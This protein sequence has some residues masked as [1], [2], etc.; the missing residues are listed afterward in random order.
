MHLANDILFR[1]PFSTSPVASAFARSLD[2]VFLTGA[3]C[4]VF[5]GRS[6][7]F[8]VKVLRPRF[9]RDSTVLPQPQLGSFAP[10][11][12]GTASVPSSWEPIAQDQKYLSAPPLYDSD[13][14]QQVS[15]NVHQSKL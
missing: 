15:C 12:Y 2:D 11:P 9:T 10:A 7:T 1:M 4:A 3:H 8:H 6:L 13:V 5:D 14:P